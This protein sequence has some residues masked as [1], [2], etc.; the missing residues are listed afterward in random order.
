MKTDKNSTVSID[1]TF[2]N[3]KG[4]ILETTIYDQPIVIN[5]SDLNVIEGL[6]E[7]LIG[8]EK[9]DKFSV[10]IPAAKAYGNHIKEL[11][12]KIPRDPNLP[13]SS[14]QLGSMID[15]SSSNNTTQKVKVIGMDLESITIDANHPLAGE[16]LS[17]NIIVLNIE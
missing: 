7:S 15:L 17:A 1:Y 16:D 9:G 5:I 2:Y 10:E 8:R 6:R 3:S 13:L 14:I 4:D 11:I 12:K